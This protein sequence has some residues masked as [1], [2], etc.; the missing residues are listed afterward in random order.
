[1][2]NPSRLPRH[3]TIDTAL[4]RFFMDLVE[5]R[6]MASPLAFRLSIIARS[7][8]DSKMILEVLFLPI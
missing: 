1:M 7:E 4:S 8:F 5:A 3:P 2:W 6:I